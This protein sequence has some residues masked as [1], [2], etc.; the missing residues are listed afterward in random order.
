MSFY[1][2]CHSAKWSKCVFRSKR[3]N[4]ALARLARGYPRTLKKA[5]KAQL[6]LRLPR[7]FELFYFG[8]NPNPP[9]ALQHLIESGLKASVPI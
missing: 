4:F 1:L 9:L 3:S 6:A 2:S 5:S 7:T 8:E